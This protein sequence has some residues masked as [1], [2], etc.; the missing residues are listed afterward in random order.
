MKPVF[1][2]N[3]IIVLALTG[4]A[5]TT[6]E[7]ASYASNPV[8]V[9]CVS[10][11]DCTEK[12]QRADQWIRK[13][14]QWPIKRSDN[15]VIEIERART[16]WHTRTYYRVTREATGDTMAKIRMYASCLPSVNCSPNETE[17]RAAFARF[18]QTG[19]DRDDLH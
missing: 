7:Q 13:H 8:T 15:E 4:C 19:E 11:T 14:S 9:K 16:R 5:A 6:P 17:A 3:A 12:W 10:E 2:L 1:I 18:L